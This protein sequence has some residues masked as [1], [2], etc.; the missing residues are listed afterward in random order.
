MVDFDEFDPA[1][2]TKQYFVEWLGVSLPLPRSLTEATQA[3]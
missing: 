3:A 2:E 1:H